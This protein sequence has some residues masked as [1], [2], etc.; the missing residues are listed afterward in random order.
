MRNRKK[1]ACATALFLLGLAGRASGQEVGS[2]VK[3]PPPRVTMA[4]A[5]ALNGFF[6]GPDSMFTGTARS[7][8]FQGT[9]SEATRGLLSEDETRSQL[10]DFVTSLLIREGVLEFDGRS[11]ARA[12]TS[13]KPTQGSRPAWVGQTPTAL[14]LN[15]VGLKPRR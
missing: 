9:T 1:A 4:A 3:I 11:S 15:R 5:P 14:S 7:V 6:V 13:E 8:E 10:G 2:D 12:A